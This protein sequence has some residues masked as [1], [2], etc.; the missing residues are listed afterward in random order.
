MMLTTL[1]IGV[2][3]AND[4]AT[5]NALGPA[6]ADSFWVVAALAIVMFLLGYDLIRRLRRAKYR[7]EIQEELAAEIAERDAAAAGTAHPGAP[8]Q[9]GNDQADPAGNAPKA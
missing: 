1:H 7:A 5:E 3:A 9:S 4:E 6:F 2:M 8:E